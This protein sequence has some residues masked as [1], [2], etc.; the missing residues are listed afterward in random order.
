M[1]C[2]CWCS[3]ASLP[4]LWRSCGAAAVSW[5]QL[6]ALVRHGLWT[7]LASMWLGRCQ[8]PLLACLLAALVLCRGRR[9]CVL[10]QGGLSATREPVPA[11]SAELHC[12]IGNL[13]GAKVLKPPL[14]PPSVRYKRF[15]SQAFGRRFD[16]RFFGTWSVD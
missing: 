16:S 4:A 2:Q 1:F 6:T 11:S 9:S 10:M 7:S 12:V 3:A 13:A 15:A 14:G 8:A 5:L